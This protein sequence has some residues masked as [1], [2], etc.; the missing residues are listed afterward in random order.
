[1]SAK[2]DASERLL[3]ALSL[4]ILIFSLTVRCVGAQADQ[5]TLKPT[6]DAYVD[7]SNPDSNYGGRNYLQILN[8]NSQI[9]GNGT[10]ESIIWL[11][12]NLS[13]V[14]EGA[15]ID[16]ST[17]QLW[18]SSVDGWFNVNAY[19]GTDL[20]NTS[21]IIS[22]TELTIM[23]S[24]MPFYNSTSMDSVLVEDSGQ[25]YNWSVL[26]AVRDALN[27]TPRTITIVL[28]DPSPHGL[29]SAV[30]FDSK[31]SSTAYAPMLTVHWSGITQE[32]PTFLIL[33][34]FTIA[35]LLA[36]VV[37]RK[38]AYPARMNSAR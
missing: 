23:Y 16:G 31:E 13:S 8:Y 33:A 1:M 27:S 21:A 2:S 17:L 24:N 30:W 29:V 10:Q 26:D 14:P 15:V 37:Y 4:A 6:D 28:C 34:L 5:V 12:F 38:K 20:L 18:T 9:N 22:W 36:T 19:S 25:W 32:F 35:S 11:K 3:V 7:S